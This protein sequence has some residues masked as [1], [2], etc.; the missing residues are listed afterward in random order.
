MRFVAIRGTEHHRGK[1][2]GT[3]AP[4]DAADKIV[5]DISRFRREMDKLC[6]WVFPVLRGRTGM[7]LSGYNGASPKNK[8]WTVCRRWEDWRSDGETLAKVSLAGDSP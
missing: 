1:G 5:I 2:A 3:R 6:P 7:M 4:G 8:L